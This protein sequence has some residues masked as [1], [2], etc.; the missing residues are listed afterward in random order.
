MLLKALLLGMGAL[1]NAIGGAFLRRQQLVCLDQSGSRWHG[2]PH[3]RGSHYWQFVARAR[4][5][6]LRSQGPW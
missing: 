4:L 5:A 2:L 3:G 1:A 6:T